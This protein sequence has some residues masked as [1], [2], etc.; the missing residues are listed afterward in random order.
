MLA[1]IMEKPPRLVWTKLDS[2]YESGEATDHFWG[3]RVATGWLIWNRLNHTIA[4][5]PDAAAPVASPP[6]AP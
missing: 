4:F 5:V 1:G 3:A 6:N 2:T